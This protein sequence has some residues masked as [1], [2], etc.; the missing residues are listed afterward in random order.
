MARWLRIIRVLLLLAA[1][2][3]GMAFLL[4][5]STSRLDSD[6]PH[7]PHNE[8]SISAATG[9]PVLTLWHKASTLELMAINEPKHQDCA[10][11]DEGYVRPAW[12]VFT[13]SVIAFVY[14]W[15]T[16]PE[17]LYPLP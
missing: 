7:F 10:P 8:L 6:V 1:Y 13:I 2:F 11:I 4:H 17:I 12:T 3:I 16:S 9:Q 5:A 14:V 15:L